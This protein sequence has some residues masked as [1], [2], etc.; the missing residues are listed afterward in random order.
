MSFSDHENCMSGCCAG[1]YVK[2]SGKDSKG[3]KHRRKTARQNA[4][5]DVQVQVREQRKN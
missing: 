2:L 1:N 4:D 5:K 3:V